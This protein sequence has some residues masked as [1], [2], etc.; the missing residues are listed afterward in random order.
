ML[1]NNKR[2]NTFF[3]MV[4]EGCFLTLHKLILTLHNQQRS[5]ELSQ[6]IKYL[7]H[8]QSQKI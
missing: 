5:Q 1:T 2:E 8:R 3:F 6:N 7:A 4:M